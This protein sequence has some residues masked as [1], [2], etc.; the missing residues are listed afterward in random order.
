MNTQQ[1]TFP[2]CFVA[3]WLFSVTAYTQ[4]ARIDPFQAAGASLEHIINA[5][6]NIF[7]ACGDGALILRTTDFGETWERIGVSL[8]EPTLLKRMAIVGQS[9][10]VCIGHLGTALKSTDRG[11]TWEK[12]DLGTQEH[13]LDIASFGVYGIITGTNGNYWITSNGGSTWAAGNLGLDNHIFAATVLPQGG[14]SVTGEDGLWA[15]WRP[16]TSKWETKTG[17]FHGTAYSLISYSDNE[18]FV[19]IRDQILHSTDA[20]NTWSPFLTNHNGVVSLLYRTDVDETVLWALGNPDG[21]VWAFA[22]REWRKAFTGDSITINA[23]AFTDSFDYM[24]F[25]GEEGTI[26]RMDNH[27][28]TIEVLSGAMPLMV[29]VHHDATGTLSAGELGTLLRSD[30]SLCDGCPENAFY[31]AVT[32]KNSITVLAGADKKLYSSTDDGATWTV[33]TSPTL[34]EV[35]IITLASSPGQSDSGNQFWAVS[36]GA[37]LSSPNGRTWTS[38][39]AFTDRE[40][41]KIAVKDESTVAVCG[42]RG[43]VSISTDGGD[44]WNNS[45]VPAAIPLYGITFVTNGDIVITGESAVYRSTDNGNTF[46]P[47]S[48]AGEASTFMDIH[49]ETSITAAVNLEG[50]LYVK[51]GTSAQWQRFDVGVP[52][53]DVHVNGTTIVACG[54]FGVVIR[55]TEV[56]TAVQDLHVQKTLFLSP[57]PASDGEVRI[58]HDNN[59]PSST[60]IIVNAMGTVVLTKPLDPLSNSIIVPI[61]SLPSGVFVVTITDVHGNIR[62][63]GN[64]VVTR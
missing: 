31:T 54:A 59:I 20:G 62:S 38:R 46:E 43:F 29:S 39:G 56:Q 3:F 35:Q 19:G 61:G 64:L 44:T 26:K 50:A 16:A 63:K 10:V 27:K 34:E 37:V 17:L 53:L 36:T 18:F 15:R 24:L 28:G 52:L 51:A 11:L 7:L 23:M 21:D 1:Y 4:P 40:L 57:N 14:I 60:V 33:E 25:V 48:I 30:G 58:D 45:S 6:E 32:R 13:L 9:S 5:G 41:L 49:E 2:F 12:L 42:R 22:D 8:A 55:Y 47:T